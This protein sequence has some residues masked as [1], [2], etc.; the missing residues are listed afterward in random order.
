MLHAVITILFVSMHDRFSVAF[1]AKLMPLF[2]QCGLEVFIV[3]NFT[4][5]YDQDASI[6]VKDWLLTTWYVNNRETCHTQ[7]YIIFYPGTPLIWTP[8]V[9][10]LTHLPYQLFCALLADSHINKACY[11]THMFKS[12]FLPQGPL[13]ICCLFSPCGIF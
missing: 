7:R 1:R 13:H 4:I 6:L 3:V 9:N 12:L 5:K 2:F 10:L 8:V 11:S